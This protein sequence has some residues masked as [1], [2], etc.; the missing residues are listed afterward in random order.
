MKGDYV[1]TVLIRAAPEDVWR[2]LTA[3][4][5]YESWNPE[6]IGVDGTFARGERL[7][8][9]VRIGGGAV[10]S[11]TLRVTSYDPPHRMEWTGGLPLGL[12]VGK[13]TLSVTPVEGGSQFRMDV[14]MTGPLAPMILKSVGDRQP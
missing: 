14:S 5:G 2:T 1:T 7:K 4:E 3:A 9:R 11:M 6:I 13:R 10:R 8:V 12:F